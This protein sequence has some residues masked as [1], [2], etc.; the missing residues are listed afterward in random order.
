MNIHDTVEF[1]SNI[2]HKTDTTCAE[3]LNRCIKQTKK[4]IDDVM[5]P[6]KNE[7]RSMLDDPR[8]QAILKDLKDE[9]NSSTR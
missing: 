5:I 7:S 2:D 3:L 8:Y 1:Q 9:N 6:V 4:R